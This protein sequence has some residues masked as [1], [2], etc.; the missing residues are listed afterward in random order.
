MKHD[1]SLSC[2]KHGFVFANSLS[3]RLVAFRLLTICCFDLKIARPLVG[4]DVKIKVI[5]LTPHPPCTSWASDIC[6]W[7]CLG[8]PLPTCHTRQRGNGSVVGD[9]ITPQFRHVQLLQQRH[10]VPAALVGCG[11]G[12]CWGTR[13]LDSGLTVSLT[14]SLTFSFEVQPCE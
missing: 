11:S 6:V 7:D 9:N 13:T 10:G 2:H 14:I 3:A 4:M 5:L 1:A 8:G 12:S